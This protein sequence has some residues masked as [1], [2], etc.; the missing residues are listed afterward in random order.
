[1]FQ[2]FLGIVLAAVVIVTGIFSYYQESKSS[3]IMESFK[4][5]V[6]QV[7]IFIKYIFFLQKYSVKLKLSL[8]SGSTIIPFDKTCKDVFHNSLLF[9]SRYPQWS[10]SPTKLFS[11]I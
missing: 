10:W 7:R 3:K 9:H 4:N 8:I 6:P 1:M 2:L 5:M 11:T